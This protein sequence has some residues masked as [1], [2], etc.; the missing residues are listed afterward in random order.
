MILAASLAIA[1]PAFSAIVFV[2]GDLEG[3]AASATVPSGWSIVPFD[4]PFS[5]ATTAGAANGD[6][7]DTA[8]PQ[9]AGGIFG[10][11]HSGS[12]FVGGAHTTVATVV[13]QE[14]IEQTVSG[15]TVG[16]DYSFSF[17][18]ANVGTSNGRDTEGSWRVYANGVLVGTTIPTTGTL[19]YNDPEKATSLLWEERSITFTADAESVTLSFLAY[20]ADGDISPQNGVYMGIDSFSGIAPVPEPAAAMLGVIGLLGLMRRRR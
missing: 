10:A 8:G 3:T 7:V 11:P 18:Q 5:E 4:A 16:Q 2:N 13:T 20:D 15:F 12:S 1:T 19:A 6:I 17:F 14:G 9:L